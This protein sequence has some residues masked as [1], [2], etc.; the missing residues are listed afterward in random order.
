MVRRMARQNPM[1]LQFFLA[2]LFPKNSNINIL[3]SL[4]DNE[5]RMLGANIQKDDTQVQL[6]NIYSPNKPQE[7]PQ[8]F[9]NISKLFDP[10]LNIIFGGDFNMVQ[11]VKMDRAGGTPS[12]THLSGSKELKNILDEHKLC[13]IWKTLNIN[14]KEFTWENPSKTIK[15]RIDKTIHF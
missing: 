5:G 3:K 10:K 4:T 7:R 6:I 12:Q 15:G 11:N 9:L 1:E 14:K 13:D 2:V 8:F